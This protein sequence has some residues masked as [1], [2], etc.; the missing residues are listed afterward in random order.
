MTPFERSRENVK[1]LAMR[2]NLYDLLTQTVEDTKD[3]D[4]DE[5]QQVW[6]IVLAML[7]VLD[8]QGDIN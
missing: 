8:I 4:E 1:Q 6:E 2:L 7:E 3:M 5:A